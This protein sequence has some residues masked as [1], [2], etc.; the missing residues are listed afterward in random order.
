VKRIAI[1][2]TGGR[3]RQFECVILAAGCWV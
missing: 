3:R 2:V 1:H